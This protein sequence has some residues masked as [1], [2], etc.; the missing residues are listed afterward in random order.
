VRHHERSLIVTV[1]ESQEGPSIAQLPGR[2]RE[3][4]GALRPYAES[5]A[6][7]FERAATELEQALDSIHHEVLTLSQAA[8]D[9]GYTVEHLG[10][11]VRDEKI[12]NAGKKGSPR[13]RRCDLP[14]RPKQSVA[15]VGTGGY[16]PIAYA[17][18]LLSRRRGG[19]D[20]LS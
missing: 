16:D 9:S 13:I 6:R 1:T 8:K 15:A 14:R 2:W 4:A 10:R 3:K 19:A 18:K 20:G 5:A 11:L 12:P 7:A 17:Q